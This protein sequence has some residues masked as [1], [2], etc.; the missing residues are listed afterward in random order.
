MLYTI[1][2]DDLTVT[3]EECSINDYS[4]SMVIYDTEER[5]IAIEIGSH[6]KFQKFMTT[7]NQVSYTG[8]YIIEARY[9][10]PK[11]ILTLKYE[12]KNQ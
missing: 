3:T 9:S 5:D 2:L 1:T 12:G 4:I 6:L 7:V 11:I 10:H 8:C